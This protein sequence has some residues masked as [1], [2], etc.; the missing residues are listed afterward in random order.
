MVVFWGGAHPSP[1]TPP[2][3]STTS[4]HRPRPLSEILNTP[5]RTYVPHVARNQSYDMQPLW[6]TNPPVP[7]PR[8]KF[9]RS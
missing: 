7:T 2:P 4:A 6:R 9:S 5:L 8:T 3:H 1:E